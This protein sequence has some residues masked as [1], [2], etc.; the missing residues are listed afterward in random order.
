L[1]KDEDLP[2]IG[3][4]VVEARMISGSFTEISEP[5]SLEAGMTRQALPKAP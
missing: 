2:S 1:S 4:R 3:R 5:D